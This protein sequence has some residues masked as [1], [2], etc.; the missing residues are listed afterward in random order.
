MYNHNIYD[1]KSNNWRV[2]ITTWIDWKW[3]SINLWVSYLALNNIILKQYNLDIE[4]FIK[5]SRVQWCF[6]IDFYK[7]YGYTIYS[8][9]WNICIGK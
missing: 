8:T 2:I 7:E 6:E 1:V 9:Y 4:E 3:G 5:K